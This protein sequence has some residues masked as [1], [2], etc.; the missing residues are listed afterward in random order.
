MNAPAW[1]HS[2]IKEIFPDIFYVTGTNITTCDTTELQHSRN[3][4]IVRE[5]GKLSLINTVRL[6]ETGL[7][8][9]A[10]LGEVE[11]IIRIGAFHGRDDEFYCDHYHGKLWAL[12]GMPHDILLQPNSPMPFADCSVFIFETS[13]HPEAIL[14][15]AKAGGI[16]VTCDSIKNWESADKF[17]SAATA[18]LY[19]QQNLFGIASISDVWLQ[20]CNVK[21]EDFDKLKSLRFKHLLSAHGQ[22]LLNNAYESV[23][24]TLAKS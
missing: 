23:M 2:E 9:L 6:N 13:K 1:P 22:P 10:A 7:A 20:A 11:N 4:I 16:L 15:I 12:P 18:K 17:F 3:M 19:Q 8:A 14:H 24:K 5:N 21:T